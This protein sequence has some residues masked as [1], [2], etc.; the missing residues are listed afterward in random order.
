MIS[1]VGLCV[2]DLSKLHMYDFLCKFKFPM[3]D[4][5]CYEL[6]GISLEFVVCV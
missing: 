6:Q 4:C 1:Y 2:L 5:V 3:L